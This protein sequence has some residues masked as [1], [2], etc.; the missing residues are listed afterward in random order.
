MSDRL[1]EVL[2]AWNAT[3]PEDQ[4]LP[5]GDI[6]AVGR[7]G[8]TEI[9]LTEAGVQWADALNHLIK[10]VK[11]GVNWDSIARSMHPVLQ[12]RPAAAPPTP[13][14]ATPA[15]QTPGGGG[16]LD[17]L[18]DLRQRMSPG[19]APAAPPV[20]E[21]PPGPVPEPSTGTDDL[22]ERRFT[23]MSEMRERLLAEEHPVIPR[24]SVS[25]Q[26][27]VAQADVWTAD[28][29]R[30]VRQFPVSVKELAYELS[31]V[32]LPLRPAATSAPAAVSGARAATPP[33]AGPAAPPAASVPPRDTSAVGIPAA[34]TA[35]AN[36]GRLTFAPYDGSAAPGEI[37]AVH[38]VRTPDGGHLLSWPANGRAPV[39]I[40]RVVRG[41]QHAPY[42]PDSAAV[43]A[44]T[45]D[46][47]ALDETPFPHA[48][49]HYQVWRHEGRGLD[50]ATMS[51]PVLVAH[52]AAVAPPSE[53]VVA[54]DTGLVTA[55]W[56][57]RPGTERVC[58]YRVPVEEAFLAGVGSP[59][60]RILSDRP[61]L[62]GFSDDGVDPGRTYVYQII[63]EAQVGA[64]TETAPPLLREVAVPARHEPVLDLQFTLNDHAGDEASFMLTWTDP[65]DGRVLVYRTTETPAAGYDLRPIA[66]TALPSAG[67]LPEFRLAHPIDREGRTA[68]MRSVPWPRDWSRAFF[69]AVVEL[70]DAVYVGNTVTGI[71]VG[72]PG[73]PKMI[74]RVDHALLT[75]DFPEGAREVRVYVGPT[76]VD[77]SAVLDA[78][79]LAVVSRQEYDAVGSVRLD[80]TALPEQCDLHLVAY[81]SHGDLTA[82]SA[83][84]S[85]THVPLLVLDYR[86][87]FVM[88]LTAAA[89]RP[90]LT[91][92]CDRDLRLDPGIGFVLGYHGDRLPL[93]VSDCQAIVALVP[94]TDEEVAPQQRV[95]VPRLAMAGHDEPGWK[96]D[97]A[98]WS[99]ALSAAGNGSG[100]VRL[101]VH[102]PR[103]QQYVALLDPPVTSL[104]VGGLLRR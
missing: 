13:D 10:Q 68:S 53:V 38:V 50:E 14:A 32:L 45:A 91:I 73:R 74:E 8:T 28:E 86:V 12:P 60:Y 64:Q 84:V 25:Y 7:A 47:R 18:N 34:P 26:R 85:L 35:D 92:R 42:N 22:T 76:G 6:Q 81:A 80:R 79:P 37:A 101:F 55:T 43:V 98:S 63:V 65:P 67:L 100:F 30:A 41:D 61:L 20:V 36:L 5:D 29:I 49:R 77:A 2:D 44:V 46:S 1:I 62:G 33:V 70:G 99:A 59:Q 40:H 16:L 24:L 51:Q 72:A 93:T 15:P 3:L 19:G 94:D 71:R 95:L 97:A 104:R 31:Q 75:F 90:K 52:G 83:A 23:A 89:R 103:Y 87:S 54:A 102:E 17:R 78:Q 39:V 66:E 96:A 4:R 9:G 48:V 57:V 21:T 69:T 11:F 56:E 88:G 82:R 27:A 58:V